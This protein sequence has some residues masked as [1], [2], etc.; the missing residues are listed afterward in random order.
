MS[1]TGRAATSLLWPTLFAVAGT[2]ILIGLGTWQLQRKAWK[3]GLIAQIAARTLAEPIPL[4]EAV[5]RF[6][7]GEDLEYTRVRAAGRFIA[8]RE[9]YYW[10]PGPAGPGWHVY[11]PLAVPDGGILIVNRGFVEE[12]YR[13]P[14]KRPEAFSGETELIGLL[15]KPEAKTAFA[16]TSDQ[17]RGLWYWRDI[18]GMA[19][20]LLGGDARKALPFALDAERSAGPVAPH[21]PQGGGTRLVIPNS[22]LQYAVT[23]YGLSLTLVGVYAALVVSRLKA[24]RADEKPSPDT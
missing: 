17:A 20:F 22:H 6:A 1:R 7:K 12:A 14:A 13:D 9:A 21:A 5:R 15:R 18:G 23:W 4:S 3:E 2:A 19:A 10:A 16:A 11:A 8:G 24:G